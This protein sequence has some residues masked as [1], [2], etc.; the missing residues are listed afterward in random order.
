M[1]DRTNPKDLM[2]CKKVPM[3]SVIPPAS[4]IYEGLA[5][6]YGAH[7]A[8]KADG[9]LGY[10]PFNWRENN[11]V[12]SIYVDACMRHLMSWVD[13][14]A[15]ASDSDVPHLGHAKACLGILA[16]AIENGNLVDDRPSPGPAARL[17]EQ[18]KVE[19]EPTMQEVITAVHDELVSSRPFMPRMDA[20]CSGAGSPFTPSGLREP[21]RLGQCEP[22]KSE[23]I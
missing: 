17:L 6:R 8:P 1:S 2:G 21:S 13:G 7:L 3:L 9:T 19:K 10:G 11:V 16:D 15:N 12:A 18:H 20:G 14:E 23:K 4:I 5:M 22:N